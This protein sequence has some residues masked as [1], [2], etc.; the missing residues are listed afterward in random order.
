MSPGSHRL[1]YVKAAIWA[2]VSTDEQA[3]GNQ[4]A[5]L[6]QWA[7]RRDLDV[8]TE[9]ALD[10]AS[11]WKGEHRDQL[12]QALDDA[13]AGRY[14]V[15]LV[16]A[17]DR[18]SREGIEATQSVMRQLADRGVGAWSLKE[19]W[20]ETSDPHIKELIS[21]IM[22]W[23]ARIESERRTERVE[24]GL[25]R[26]RREGLPVGRQSARDR[27]PRKRS[28]YVARWEREGRL[29]DPNEPRA[30]REVT[31]DLGAVVRADRRRCDRG[32][33]RADRPPHPV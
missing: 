32:G 4:L 22:A 17:L 10:G 33:R 13:R 15:L 9:Y 19:S 18:L 1:V 20:T 7:G 25:D 29:A 14:E 30:G 26:R 2:R 28:G 24:A 12:R 5:E 21:A 11:A 31:R 8:V 3:A 27:K 16:R 23:V 6:R